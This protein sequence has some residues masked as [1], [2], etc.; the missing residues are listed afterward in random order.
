MIKLLFHQLIMG[1]FYHKYPKIFIDDERETNFLI[2]QE[3]FILARRWKT[4]KDT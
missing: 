4:F 3:R 2:S 1:L